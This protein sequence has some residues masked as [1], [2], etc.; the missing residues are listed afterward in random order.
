MPINANDF[1]R[2]SGLVTSEIYA[3]ASD[4]FPAVSPSITREKNISHSAFA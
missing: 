2:S 1:A 3:W 4:R